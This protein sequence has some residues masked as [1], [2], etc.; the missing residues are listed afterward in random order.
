MILD[1]P[2]VQFVMLFSHETYYGNDPAAY[3]RYRGIRL[4][5]KE[6]LE[7]WGKLIVLDEKESLEKLAE[8]LDGLVER[9][10]I[11]CIKY[12]RMPLKE[13]DMKECVMCVF[14]DDRQKDE[15]SEILTSLGA[16]TRAW[17]PE[18][19]V[20]E[21]WSPGG[22]FLE[23]WIESMGYEGEMA[24]AIREDSRRIMQQAYGDEDAPATG[25][26]QWGTSYE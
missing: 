3:I 22:M 21:G 16:T 8:K 14:C 23:K 20:I 10:I 24:D 2:Q 19:D 6:Y 5:N 25:W 18:K 15:I 26:D 12:D 9:G 4:T 7:H 11:P 17:V 13:F 1:D